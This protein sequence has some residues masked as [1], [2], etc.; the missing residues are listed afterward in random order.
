MDGVLH[1]R[2]QGCGHQGLHGQRVLP[3]PRD[4][5]VFSSA[6]IASAINHG[7]GR[8][9]EADVL[10][11]E[12]EYS[13]Y[14]FDAIQVEDVGSTTPLEP[15]LYELVGETARP[16]EAAINSAFACAGASSEE[17]TEL[18]G[19]LVRLGILG[20]ETHLDHFDYTE[21]EGEL[22]RNQGLADKIAREGDTARRFEIHPAFRAFLEITEQKD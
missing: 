14:A 15:F 5:I 21:D 11:G 4:I 9:E 22:R 8:V 7:S 6:A 1:T 10:R 16:T 3:R 20:L 18:V 2:S 19:R 17:A 12:Q 13:R